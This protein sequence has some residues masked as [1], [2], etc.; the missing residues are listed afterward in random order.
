MTWGRRAACAVP[1]RELNG[2]I[3]RLTLNVCGTRAQGVQ[4]PRGPM[5]QPPCPGR[6]ARAAAPSGQETLNPQRPTVCVCVC[7]YPEAG[8]NPA[9]GQRWPGKAGEKLRPQC[10][11]WAGSGKAAAGCRWRL[12]YSA[13]RIDEHVSAA[14]FTTRTV[15]A[16]SPMRRSWRTLRGK[17]FTEPPPQSPPACV[18]PRAASSPAASRRGGAGRRSRTACDRRRRRR[19]RDPCPARRGGRNPCC[20]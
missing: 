10:A 12:C 2:L 19:T 6:P 13:P 4:L 16:D 11:V 7:G 5:S 3:E 8:R 17:H 14:S 20:V 9:C 18:A 1:H 15:P